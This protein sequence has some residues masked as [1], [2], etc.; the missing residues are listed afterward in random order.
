MTRDDAAAAT[1]ATQLR[2]ALEARP[3]GE[4]AG[5][6]LRVISLKS[7][8]IHTLSARWRQC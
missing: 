2:A 3:E 4:T 7:G 1:P 5:N 6:L 8:A